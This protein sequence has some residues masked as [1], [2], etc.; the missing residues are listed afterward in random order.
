LSLQSQEICDPQVSLAKTK[1]KNM[2]KKPKHKQM[3]KAVLC[4]L[5][6]HWKQGAK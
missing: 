1:T 4:P 3:K 6:V 2:N 5:M